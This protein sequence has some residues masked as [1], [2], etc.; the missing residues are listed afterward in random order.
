M[1]TSYLLRLIFTNVNVN[2]HE[3][4]VSENHYKSIKGILFCSEIGLLGTSDHELSDFPLF[5]VFSMKR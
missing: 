4:K 1:A 3:I 2:I 5:S